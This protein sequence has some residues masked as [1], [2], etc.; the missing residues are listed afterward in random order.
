MAS[1]AADPSSGVAGSLGVC[2][3]HQLFLVRSL[4]LFPFAVCATH[5]VGRLSNPRSSFVF[6]SS[7][8]LG[9]SGKSQSKQA[10]H[11]PRRLMLV[12]LKM[13]SL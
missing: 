2:I 9:L 5:R 7:T 3:W 13:H 11:F 1:N 10:H 8:L 4:H 12:S 6:G